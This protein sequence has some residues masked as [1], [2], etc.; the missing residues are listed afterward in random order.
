MPI[1]IS[2]SLLCQFSK[3]KRPTQRHVQCGSACQECDS[4]S[5]IFGLL[6]CG[7]LSLSPLVRAITRL[8]AQRVSG[9]SCVC[10]SRNR[11]SFVRSWFDPVSIPHRIGSTPASHAADSIRNTSGGS[12]LVY[13]LWSSRP[14]LSHSPV[15]LRSSRILQRLRKSIRASA[16]Q[17]HQS[18]KS[19]RAARAAEQHISR[20]ADRQISRA[21]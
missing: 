13:R 1:S 15:C 5:H 4:N 3:T 18:R 11:R 6:G 8:R 12:R 14:I 19:S 21:A 2:R 17:E 9:A 7:H 16:Q 10:G 20:S